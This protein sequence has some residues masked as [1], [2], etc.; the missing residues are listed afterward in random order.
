EDARG[1]ARGAGLQD[2][3]RQ[4]DPDARTRPGLIGRSARNNMTDYDAIDFFRGNE[5][6]ADPYSY[7]S[8]L[9]GQCPVQ[10][11]SHHDVM[12]VTGYQEAG[13]VYNATARFSSCN[14]PT[15]PSPG[16]S[17]SLE[18]DDVSAL[19][20]QHRHELPFADQI[21]PFDPPKHTAHRG[22]LMRLI[23]PK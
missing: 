11:E 14:P 7:F 13:A 23:T 1:R 9:R 5:C 16:F 2:P 12:M 8:W 15:G 10:R 4:R 17:V 22:L 19:I 21:L 20:E 3:A 18:G 6:I